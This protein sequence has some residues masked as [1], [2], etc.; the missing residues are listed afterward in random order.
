MEITPQTR[1]L[2][3]EMLEG[4]DAIYVDAMLGE[5]HS[6]DEK[7]PLT[8]GDVV[9]YEM[10]LSIH[11][12]FARSYDFLLEMHYCLELVEVDYLGKMLLH[13]QQVLNLVFLVLGAY[14]GMLPSPLWGGTPPMY[15]A[16]ANLGS[17]G[18]PPSPPGENGM[19]IGM[20]MY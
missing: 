5:V 7:T 13:P 15:Q 12:E 6:L 10:Q 4:L 8:S 20:P 18:H 17:W 3:D 2:L 19:G 16:R 1:S 11:H 14:P 9:D